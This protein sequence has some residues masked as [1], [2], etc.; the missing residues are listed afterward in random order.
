MLYGNQS[1]Y[2]VCHLFFVLFFWMGLLS[3]SGEN[4]MLIASL[5]IYSLVTCLLLNLTAVCI[6]VYSVKGNLQVVTGLEKL[7]TM[8][9]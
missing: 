8:I 4:F 1:I 3:T 6:D 5:K 7:Q 9:T 2:H